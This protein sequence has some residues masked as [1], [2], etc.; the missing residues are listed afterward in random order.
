M[1]VTFYSII[2]RVNSTKQASGTGTA[3]DCILKDRSSIVN[4]TIALKMAAS[5]TLAAP[6]WN[7]AY[8]ASYGR[9]YWVD[10]WTFEDRQWIAALSVDVLASYKTE[11]G[12]LSKFVIRTGSDASN[13]AAGTPDALF[14]AGFSHTDS[15]Q[16][17]DITGWADTP[18]EGGTYVVGIVGADNNL[19]QCGAAGYGTISAAS[20][21][22]LMKESFAA[23]TPVLASG[24]SVTDAICALI[25]N[26]VKSV[27]NPSDF[28]AS[29]IW[30][31]YAVSAGSAFSKPYL[32]F[33][34]TQTVVMHPLTAAVYKTSFVVPCETLIGGATN[35]VENFFVEP[36]CSYYLEFWPFGVFPV[37]GRTLVAPNTAGIQIDLTVDQITGTAR[38][39][40]YRSTS[41]TAS[42]SGYNGAYLCGGSAQLGVRLPIGG[43][44]DNAVGAMGTLL[45]AM[46][47]T[48][49][50]ASGSYSIAGSI[51][52]GVSTAL[53]VAAAMSPRAV[54]GG[55]CTGFAG[56]S[57]TVRLHRTQ[58]IP[59]G[60]DYVEHGKAYGMVATLSTLTGYIQ[61]WDGE[62]SLSGNATREERNQIADFLTGGFFYE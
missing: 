28:I 6:S 56:I 60:A 33:V 51:G 27:M 14:P 24:W 23:R 34:Q 8:I 38:F 39:E 46:T 16:S 54:M 37:N 9:Y 11:I 12:A 61:C 44:K 13:F 40:A 32:G 35:K 15:S 43:A 2:K 45:G 31:P 4:P 42:A 57:K 3:F 48:G 22:N 59:S 5:G 19:Y 7:Y 25:D 36:Y 49:D 30:L 10:N 18:A 17:T 41:A 52:N 62:I 50:D 20:L 58:F 1:T 26:M 21:N 29:A 53:N 55:T 47:S